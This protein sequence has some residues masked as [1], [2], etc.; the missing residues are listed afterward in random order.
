[1]RKHF[2]AVA[3]AIVSS[4]GSSAE[5]AHRGELADSRG[6]RQ[7]TASERYSTLGISRCGLPRCQA[8]AN[9]VIP[10]ANA[11]AVLSTCTA[12]ARGNASQCN[13]NQRVPAVANN[14]PA[15]PPPT[16]ISR[17]SVSCCRI[18]SSRLLPRAVRIANALL[19]AADRATS[20]L[21]RLR[22]AINERQTTA[23]RR[24]YKGVFTSPTMSSSRGRVIAPCSTGPVPLKR[25]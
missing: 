5:K 2:P 22:H 16:Q 13:V 21:E 15:T 17:L 18:K 14:T 1:M 23:A 3:R 7:G 25:R 10:S 11:T 20:R 8:P 19:R 4:T 6:L 24:I 12:Q 9:S